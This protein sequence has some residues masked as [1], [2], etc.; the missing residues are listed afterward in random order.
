M[1]SPS[2]SLC[3]MRPSRVLVLKKVD[4]KHPIDNELFSLTLCNILCVKS[5]FDLLRF[6]SN[7][8]DSFLLPWRTNMK[9]RKENP[10]GTS[11]QQLPEYSWSW[12]SV[13]LF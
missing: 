9:K 10:K 12:E 7:F 8:S 6:P 2:S 11:I 1:D 4:S 13:L 3:F 5:I